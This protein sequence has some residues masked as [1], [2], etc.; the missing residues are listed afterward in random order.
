MKGNGNIG[1]F[2][3]NEK[4]GLWFQISFYFQP[5]LG[6]RSNFDYVVFFQMGW[7][8]QLENRKGHHDLGGKHVIV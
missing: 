6:K 3:H 5:Y 2:V 7:N 1:I 4:T 8:H